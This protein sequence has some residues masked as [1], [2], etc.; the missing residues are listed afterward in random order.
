MR[1][2]TAAPPG[3]SGG[4]IAVSSRAT[5][6]AIE[7]SMSLFT[8]SGGN[9]A[10]IARST[11]VSAAIDPC[12]IV[13]AVKSS[14]NAPAA[15][16]AAGPNSTPQCR[17][18]SAATEDAA[19]RLPVVA[20]PREQRGREVRRVAPSLRGL[21]IFV[22]RRVARIDHATIKVPG[23]MAEHRHHDREPEEERDRADEQQ[24]ADDQ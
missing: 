5:S 7:A 6:R 4:R 1:T 23:G 24:R 19:L 11:V 18:G 21:V 10:G 3:R 13:P 22:H 16:W 15:G 9:I 20:S 8:P 17:T 2:A 14:P 12:I